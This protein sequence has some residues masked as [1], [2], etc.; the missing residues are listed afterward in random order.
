MGDKRV[1]KLN[2]RPWLDRRPADSPATP[3]GTEARIRAQEEEM[4]RQIAD[5]TFGSDAATAEDLERKLI[6]SETLGQR[7]SDR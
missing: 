1:Q 7:T 5:G 6:S 3:S 4:D 2:P